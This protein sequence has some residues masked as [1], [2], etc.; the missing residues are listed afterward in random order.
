MMCSNFDVPKAIARATKGVFCYFEAPSLTAHTLNTSNR[1][2][3]SLAHS[4]AFSTICLDLDSEI[5]Q[6]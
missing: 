6:F 3:G 5:C 2:S 4:K 1:L